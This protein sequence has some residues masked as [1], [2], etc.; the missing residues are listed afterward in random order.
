[1]NEC[2]NLLRCRDCSTEISI[3]KYRVKEK[4][5]KSELISIPCLFL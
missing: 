5:N 3:L 4:K 2:I 1:M